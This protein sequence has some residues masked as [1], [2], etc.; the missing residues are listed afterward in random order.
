MYQLDKYYAVMLV[1]PD[2]E[3]CLQGHNLDQQL[4]ESQNN[5]IVAYSALLTNRLLPAIVSAHIKEFFLSVSAS[6]ICLDFI[7]LALLQMA[8]WKELP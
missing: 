8:G 6:V 7:N 2:R 4:K 1:C 5:E 3:Y